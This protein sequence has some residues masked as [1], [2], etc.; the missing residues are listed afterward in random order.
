MIAPCKESESIQVSRLQGG[1]LRLPVTC[2]VPAA[3]HHEGISCIVGILDP[4][5]AGADLTPTGRRLAAFFEARVGEKVLGRSRVDQQD[6]REAE[7]TPHQ[8]T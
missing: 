3:P 2:I 8:R 6:G 5:A 4:A 1:H 7:A